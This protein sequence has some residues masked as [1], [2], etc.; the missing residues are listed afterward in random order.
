MTPPPAG[1]LCYGDCLDWMARWDDSTVDLVYLDPP[2]NSNADYN[3]LYAPG[4]AGGAQTRA[5]NDTW[6]WDAEAGE[7]LE[8]YR[9]AVA[10]PA[11]K[12]IVGLAGM[13]GESGMLAYLT[14]M[15]ERLEHCHRLLKPTGSLYLHCDPT[16]SHY[17]KALLDAIFGAHTFRNEIIWKRTTAHSGTKGYGPVHDTILFYGRSDNYRWNTVKQTYD[18]AYI[19]R[20]YRHTDAAGRRYRTG[21]LTGAGIRTGE[22]GQPWHGVDPT[23]IGRH[24]AVP[25]RF[26][27]GAGVPNGVQAGLDHLD[28]VGRIHWP[29]KADGMPEF[30]RYLDDMAGMQVQDVVTDIPP[31]NSQAKERLGYQTQKPLALLDRIIKASTNEGDIVLDPFCGCGTTVEA[32]RKLGRQW[33]GI[34]ISAFAVDLVK[35]IRLKDP[36]IQTL[37]IPADLAGARKLAAEKPFAFESWAVTRLPGFAPNTK[38]VGDG[39][40][41]GR[42]TL[43]AQP[44]DADSRLALAQV[45]GGKFSASYFRD[46]RHVIDRDRAALGCFITLVPPPSKSRADAKLEGRVHVAGQPYDRLQLWSIADYFDDRW[47]A[48]P[49]MTDPYSGKPINQ[50][51]LF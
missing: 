15:A 28:S 50:P 10:R 2:F 11:H 24:W 29:K 42:A 51:A 22:S 16:A 1:A 35:D 32:A 18:P 37:G 39:G 46:F 38:Q 27:G 26:P 8:R 7:R 49:V 4:A 45:K 33:V 5:F 20:K 36:T 31:I 23:K 41:D 34:D 13:L 14:Y 19:S 44:D 43:A 9:A 21:D 12:A 48:L 30:V 47:P 17:L 25:R 3:V 6:S 40:I